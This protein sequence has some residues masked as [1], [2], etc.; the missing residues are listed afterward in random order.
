ML[1]ISSHKAYIEL[2]IHGHQF[3]RWVFLSFPFFSGSSLLWFSAISWD[4]FESQSDPPGVA[5]FVVTWVIPFAIDAFEFFLR[6][7]FIS[8]VGF[9]A[10]KHAPWLSA[11]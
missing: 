1:L 2:F 6:W 10:A 3:S 5:Q 4:Q 9:R 7:V 11:A 8:V